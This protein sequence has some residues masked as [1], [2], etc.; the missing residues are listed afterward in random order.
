MIV[1]G[2][3]THSDQGARRGR[4]APRSGPLGA[5]PDDVTRVR[6]ARP[7]ATIAIARTVADGEVS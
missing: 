2:R 5:A 7:G 6:L 1:S 3:G 4:R